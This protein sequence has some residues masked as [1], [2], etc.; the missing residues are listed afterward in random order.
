MKQCQQLLNN[1]H[2]TRTH[3]SHF[4]L[5]AENMRLLSKWKC[6]VILVLIQ[7]FVSPVNIRKFSIFVAKRSMLPRYLCRSKFQ[8]F[9]YQAKIPEYL[10][11]YVVYKFVCARYDASYIKETQRH[12]KN[13]IDE[14]LHTDSS[15]SVVNQCLPVVSQRQSVVSQYLVLYLVQCQ[16]LFSRK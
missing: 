12:I 14:D 10:K 16:S 6:L 15:Q 5:I 4:L 11:S 13:R 2:W 9:P 7:C 8:I 1:F 3:K